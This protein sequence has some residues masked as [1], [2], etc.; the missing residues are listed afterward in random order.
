MARR[1]TLDQLAAM[2]ARG[3][4]DLRREMREGFA[5]IRAVLDGHSE[6]LASHSA[7]LHDHSHRLDRIERK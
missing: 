5:A 3:F 2:T 1:M 7:I 6:T 4:E